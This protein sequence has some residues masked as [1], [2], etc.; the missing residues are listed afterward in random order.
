MVLRVAILL[1]ATLTTDWA[2]AAPRRIW[3]FV[4]SGTA[5]NYRYTI[6]VKEGRTGAVKTGTAKMTMIFASGGNRYREW[7]Y[8]ARCDVPG[9]QPPSLITQP[10][11]QL[12]V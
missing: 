8:E 3:T 1:T 12:E 9:P 2:V 4:E 5:E 7:V 11:V 10:T 6:A